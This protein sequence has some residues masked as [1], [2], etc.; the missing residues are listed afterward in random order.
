[1][2]KI[3]AISCEALHNKAFM[4][5]PTTLFFD[6]PVKS[7]NV[8]PGS[9]LPVKNEPSASFFVEEVLVPVCVD[10][11]LVLV[12]GVYHAQHGPPVCGHAQRSHD[13]ADRWKYQGGVSSV[14]YAEVKE[15]GARGDEERLYRP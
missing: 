1:M 5:R 10:E 6:I 15:Q 12:H 11:L 13:R 2:G 8:I 7:S 14:L 3:D 4:G 9:L